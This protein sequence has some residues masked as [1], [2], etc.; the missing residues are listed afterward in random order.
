MVTVRRRRTTPDTLLPNTTLQQ[1][2][3]LEDVFSGR[4]VEGQS[5]VEGG[6]ATSIILYIRLADRISAHAQSASGTA[7]NAFIT[8]I[9]AWVKS[10]GAETKSE[11]GRKTTRTN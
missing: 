8:A 6:V 9:N 11:A 1:Q 4:F 2:T 10:I 7:I 5:L 3:N